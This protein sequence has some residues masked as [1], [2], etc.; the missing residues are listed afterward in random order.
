MAFAR[1]RQPVCART[2]RA[3]RVMGS[4]QNFAGMTMTSPRHIE[5]SKP[6]L[7]ED[8]MYRVPLQ[9]SMDGNTV[10]MDV[11]RVAFAENALRMRFS[12]QKT[13]DEYKDML[14]LYQDMRP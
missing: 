1:T 2:L 13:A 14:K 7:E 8:L 11:E 3:G 4:G 6:A 12:I 10:E 9:S 5:A